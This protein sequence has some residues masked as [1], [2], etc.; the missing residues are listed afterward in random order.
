M[1][2]VLMPVG[3]VLILVAIGFRKSRRRRWFKEIPEDCVET[4]WGYRSEDGVYCVIHPRAWD[5]F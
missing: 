3:L 2:E 1:W 4:A 5:L